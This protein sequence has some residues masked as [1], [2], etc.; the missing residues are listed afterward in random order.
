MCEEAV[1]IACEYMSEIS[2]KYQSVVLKILYA[3][4]EKS[5]AEHTKSG[6]G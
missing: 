2:P 4:Y 1:S 6:G 5:K 3:Y